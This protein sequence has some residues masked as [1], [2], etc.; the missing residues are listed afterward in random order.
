MVPVVFFV[1]FFRLSDFVAGTLPSGNL[2]FLFFGLLLLQLS[3]VPSPGMFR[4]L[5]NSV[6]AGIC[7][8]AVYYPKFETVC[9]CCRPLVCIPRILFTLCYILF[10]LVRFLLLWPPFSSF[11]LVSCSLMVVGQ[12]LDGLALPFYSYRGVQQKY[13]IIVPI[14]FWTISTVSDCSQAGSLS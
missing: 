7:A 6:V 1:L 5:S 12:R 10:V 14:N 9:Y 4:P 13:T 8:A 11:L 3:I 2:N